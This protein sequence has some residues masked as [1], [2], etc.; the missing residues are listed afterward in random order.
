MPASQPLATPQ[1]VVSDSTSIV[2][3]VDSPRSAD[4]LFGILANPHRH[5]EADGSGT[6]LPQVSGPERLSL[7]DS[8]TVHMRLY[9]LPYSIRSRVTA[10]E[11]NR[12]IEWRH[13]AG[14]RWR[15][16]FQPL[17]DGGTRVTESFLSRDAVLPTAFYRLVGAFVRNDDGIRASL[18]KIAD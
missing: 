12:L 4:E 5:H 8:F 11:E 18:E 15:W 10:L 13:P 6:V 16:E 3:R 2:Y 17:A 1:R 14:H 9:G 7:G